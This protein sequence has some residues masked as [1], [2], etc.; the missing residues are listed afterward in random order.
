MME[1]LYDCQKCQEN[2]V[3]FKKG[4]FPL[5]ATGFSFSFRDKW[6][7]IFRETLTVKLYSCI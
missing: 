6:H 7:K 2:S 5:R 4:H 3:K 1:W